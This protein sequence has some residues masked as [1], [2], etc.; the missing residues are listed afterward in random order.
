MISKPS[1]NN[2][3]YATI[4]IDAARSLTDQELGERQTRDLP[5]YH[6]LSWEEFPFAFADV[7]P[8]EDATA[9][10]HDAAPDNPQSW[11]YR[12]MA[13]QAVKDW[14]GANTYLA[15]YQER[16]PAKPKAR[17]RLGAEPTN[18]SEIVLPPVS[19]TYPSAPSLFLS[20]DMEYF[21]VMAIPCC[22]LSPNTHRIRTF[23]CI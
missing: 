17:M 19:G 13:R 23:M 5:P 8:F 2:T 12:A 1:A 21:Q 15:G 20:C 9:K 22:G 7:G 11:L 14:T 4:A 16:A 10:W 6:I 18:T 3:D